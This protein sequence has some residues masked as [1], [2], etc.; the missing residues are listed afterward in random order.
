LVNVIIQPPLR[1]RFPAARCVA[2]PMDIGWVESFDKVFC[3]RSRTTQDTLRDT[4]HLPMLG[5]GYAKN[6]LLVFFARLFSRFKTAYLV[7]DNF[8]FLFESAHRR[9]LAGQAKLF[10]LGRH[11]VVH[12]ST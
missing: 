6:L 4:H 8:L 7:V 5:I 1:V 10:P 2:I 12:F 11:F 3:E 9:D